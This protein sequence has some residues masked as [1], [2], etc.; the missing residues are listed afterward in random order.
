MVGDECFLFFGDA[1][2]VVFFAR[3]G[4]NEGT[5]GSLPLSFFLYVLHDGRF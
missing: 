3:R 4:E 2:V 1:V 5:A